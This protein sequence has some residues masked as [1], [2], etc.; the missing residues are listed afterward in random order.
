MNSKSPPLSEDKCY[1]CGRTNE[2]ILSSQV[3]QLFFSPLKDQIEQYSS[4]LVDHIQQ[5]IKEIDLYTQKTEQNQFLDFT[6]QAIKTDFDTFSEKIPYLAEIIT[7]SNAKSQ[8]LAE[9]IDNI[10]WL[11]SILE[12]IRDDPSNAEDILQVKS[13][14]DNPHNKEEYYFGNILGKSSVF[15]EKRTLKDISN[16][17]YKIE[18]CKYKIDVIE[19]IHLT[20][21]VQKII[22]PELTEYELDI[23]DVFPKLESFYIDTKNKKGFK[24]DRLSFFEYNGYFSSSRNIESTDL[25][26]KV[27][28]CP[29]CSAI[30]SKYGDIAA[31][32]I[33]NYS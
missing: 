25:K 2:D 10:I 31:R 7:F 18:E 20:D 13:A 6:V 9:I 28:L 8:T 24:S 22:Q 26:I 32:D 16:L 1:T 12:K 21:E 14:E 4:E 3:I 17:I 30:Y 15:K 27:L 33:P 23:I 29:I 5:I 11:K 19:K